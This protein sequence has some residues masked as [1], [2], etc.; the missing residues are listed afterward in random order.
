[1]FVGVF[2]I[3]LVLIFFAHI[4]SML[5]VMLKETNVINRKSNKKMI[6]M[7]ISVV[8]VFAVCT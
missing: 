3:L 1:M 6:E 7:T 4:I 2:A 5:L 8:V